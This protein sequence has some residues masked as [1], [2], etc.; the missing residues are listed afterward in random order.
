MTGQRRRDRQHSSS[1]GFML[2]FTYVRLELRH[3]LRQAVV[4]AAGLAVGVAL[5]ITVSAASAGVKNAQAG[6]LRG[7]YGIGTDMTV[8]RPFSRADTSPGH[9]DKPGEHLDYLATN[10]SMFGSSAAATIAGLP[11]VRAAVGVL[12]LDQTWTP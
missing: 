12:A 8:T 6:V 2:F 5:V 9:E 4:I 11:G 7:L 3:R 1:G 10:E